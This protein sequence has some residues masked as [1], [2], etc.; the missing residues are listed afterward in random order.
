MHDY[1]FLNSHPMPAHWHWLLPNFILDNLKLPLE[2][3]SELQSVPEQ[4]ERYTHKA[5]CCTYRPQIANFLTGLALSE[6]ILPSGKL[7]T[8]VKKGVLLRWRLSKL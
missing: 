2:P 4:I 7:N 5:H 6:G 8:L 3:K 1:L